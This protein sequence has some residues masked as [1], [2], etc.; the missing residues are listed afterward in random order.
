MQ[1]PWIVP[2]PGTRLER[3]EENIGAVGVELTPEDLQEI[4]SAAA[5]ITVQGARYPNKFRRCV[6]ERKWSA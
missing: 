2:T 6:M 4:E 5:S 1:R 3:L